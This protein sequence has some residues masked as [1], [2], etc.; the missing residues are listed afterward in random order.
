MKLRDL[1][2]YLDSLEINYFENGKATNH[3]ILKDNLK[4]KKAEI[5]RNIFSHLGKTE[6][7]YDY[8]T[9][10]KNKS[11]FCRNKLCVHPD[12]HTIV[13]KGMKKSEKDDDFFTEDD[14][15][16]YAKEINLEDY[17][18]LGK[19]LYLE[20]FNETQPDFLKINERQLGLIINYM[21]NNDEKI[22]C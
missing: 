2:K 8:Y 11:G 6:V 19:K 21:E 7:K 12:C 17:H 15:I 10:R 5:L 9:I 4:N 1:Y 22:H 13:F 18:R 3:W 14:I 20:K 16:E